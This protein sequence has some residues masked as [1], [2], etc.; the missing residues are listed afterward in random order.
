MHAL[1]DFQVIM[2]LGREFPLEI[3]SASEQKGRDAERWVRSLTGCNW[4]SPVLGGL[5]RKHSL[6]V[7]WFSLVFA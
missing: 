1:L 4:H 7:G 2:S 3:G 6:G 5:Y